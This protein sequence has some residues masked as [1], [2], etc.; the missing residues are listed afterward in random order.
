MLKQQLTYNTALD[1]Y[2]Q[3]GY[4]FRFETMGLNIYAIRSKNSKSN[5]FDDIGGI[6]YIDENLKQTHFNFA[7]TTDP[8]KYYL[9]NPLNKN[10]T[11]IMVP[12]QYI[13][14]YGEGKHNGKYECFKQ[15]KP[16]QYVRDNDRNDILNFDL[17]RD[18]EL[19]KKHAFWGMNGTNLHRASEWQIIKWI[20][21]YSAGCQVVQDPKIFNKLIEIRNKSM[22]YG[23]KFWDF[24]LF[25]EW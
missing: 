22:N 5:A 8:G 4:K 16:M 18:P 10:G 1:L 24:T 3:H 20:E 25:E 7:I 21:R 6:A 13:E 2:L 12:N 23:F 19:K 11:I 15:H 17:Y 14:V 9:Q